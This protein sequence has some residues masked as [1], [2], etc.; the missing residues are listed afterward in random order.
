M[1]NNNTIDKT[2]N[3][4]AQSQYPLHVSLYIAVSL[5][6][7]VHYFSMCMNIVSYGKLN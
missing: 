7:N 4:N 6:A 3:I 1:Y 2:Q 5:T